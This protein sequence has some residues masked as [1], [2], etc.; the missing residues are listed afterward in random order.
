MNLSRKGGLSFEGLQLKWRCTRKVSKS[1]SMVRRSYRVGSEGFLL[2]WSRHSPSQGFKSLVLGFKVKADKG[3]RVV[4][5]CFGMAL[6]KDC[7]PLIPNNIALLS[8][9]EII[10]PSQ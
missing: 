9:Y 7:V 6:C 1:S 8:S 5:W 4:T 10:Q 2:S 3:P